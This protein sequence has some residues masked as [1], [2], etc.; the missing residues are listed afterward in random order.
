MNPV[1]YKR[2]PSSPPPSPNRCASRASRRRAASPCARP[3]RLPASPSGPPRP[4]T[5][6]WPRPKSRRGPLP[7]FYASPPSRASLSRTRASWPSCRPCLVTAPRA[8]LVGRPPAEGAIAA[9]PRRR[10]GAAWAV[11]GG[12]CGQPSRS[13]HTQRFVRGF[14]APCLTEGD[15]CDRQACQE[16]RV[17]AWR[18]AG[19]A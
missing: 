16:R 18:R 6:R 12:A 2:R 3:R 8:R 17:T 9:R 4:R 14:F 13:G 7:L 1:Y 19:A 5:P 10:R 15:P 11:R